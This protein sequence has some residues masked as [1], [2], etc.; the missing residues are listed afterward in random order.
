MRFFTLTF[1]VTLALWAQPP[2]GRVE[3]VVEDPSGLAVMGA[4]L[5]AENQQTG[6]RAYALS[7]DRGLY[8]FAS[9]PPGDYTVTVQAPGFQTAKLTGLVLSASITVT[10]SIRLQLGAT[11]ETI[12][13]V[14]KETTVQLADAQG[15]GVIGQRDIKMLPQKER[16]PIK[17]AIFQPGV[18]VVPG[19]I[20]MSPVNGSRVGSNEVKL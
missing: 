17:L 16:N 19:Y 9:L 10:A 5:M 12:N 3:G 18:Q 15:G 7:D 4:Q 20:G 13:V 11:S 6:F 2:V 14:A 8:A 1:C